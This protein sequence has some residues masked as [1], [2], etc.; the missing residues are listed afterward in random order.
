MGKQM[1]EIQKFIRNGNMP[2]IRYNVIQNNV[3]DNVVQRWTN[4]VRD[5]DQEWMNSFMARA[6]TPNPGNQDD[7]ALGIFN[8]VEAYV[9]IEADVWA[10]DYNGQLNNR[11]RDRITNFDRE[12]QRY[13]SQYALSRDALLN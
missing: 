12:I 1:G 7:Y 9:G 11:N 3:F 4:Q 6:S 10:P 8:L 13:K 2:S 5:V